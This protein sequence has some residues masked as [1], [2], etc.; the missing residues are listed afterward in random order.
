MKTNPTHTGTYAGQLARVK[1]AATTSTGDRLYV[2]R[3][4]AGCV[5]SNWN[6][7]APL[8]RLAADRLLRLPLR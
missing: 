6:D 2:L 4:V 5:A 8:V 7:P 3:T 1:V